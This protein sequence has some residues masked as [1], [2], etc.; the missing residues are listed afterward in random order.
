MRIAD[1]SLTAAG[2]THTVTAVAPQDTMEPAQYLIK[3]ETLPRAAQPTIMALVRP[4]GKD[5]MRLKRSVEIIFP[6][7][8]T[9][10]G[11][12]TL[13]L[14]DRIV[15]AYTPSDLT[16]EAKIKERL[17]I[18]QAFLKDPQAVSVLAGERLI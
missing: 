12:V 16:T 13:G 11:K 14:P 8:V 18:L 1:I 6:N 15:L 4:V 3:D 2:K 9:V 10:D 7:E 5:A 17:D